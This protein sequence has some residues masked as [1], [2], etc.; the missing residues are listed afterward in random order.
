MGK[1]S[2]ARVRVWVW[3]NVDTDEWRGMDGSRM[4]RRRR[5]GRSGVESD[6]GVLGVR[7]EVVVFRSGEG[8]MVMV[9]LL[10]HLKLQRSLYKRHWKRRREWKGELY[11]IH[12]LIAFVGFSLQ[13]PWTFLFSSLHKCTNSVD[14]PRLSQQKLLLRGCSCL[15]GIITDL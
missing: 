9:V 1:A 8:R 6:G 5:R 13:N 2:G 10:M 7:P 12:R 14:T 3:G 11:Y 15:I 4:E